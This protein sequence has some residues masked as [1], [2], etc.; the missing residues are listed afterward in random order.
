VGR[1]GR[2]TGPHLHYEFRIG[3]V[4]HNPLTVML[5]KRTPIQESNKRD[6]IAHAKKMIQLLDVHEDKLNVASSKSSSGFE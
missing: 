4:H 3:G 2:A 5:P 6:F 1:T